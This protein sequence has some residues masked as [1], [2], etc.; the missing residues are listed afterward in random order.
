MYAYAREV[1]ECTWGKEAVLYIDALP[2]FLKMVVG[3]REKVDDF[4]TFSVI[5]QIYNLF[6]VFLLWGTP[7]LQMLDEPCN[8]SPR[9][10]T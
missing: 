3:L 5:V 9:K 7:S 6:S 2:V 8:H 4:R 1:A 10:G